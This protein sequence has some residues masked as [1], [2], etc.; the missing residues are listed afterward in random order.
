VVAEFLQRADGRENVGLL[1]LADVAD[2]LGRQEVLVDL[3]LEGGE[4]TADDLDQLRGEVLR[5]QGV[6]PAED[7]LVDQGRHVVL[8]ALGF[9]YL[10]VGG[11]RLPPGQDVTHHLPSKIGGGTEDAWRGE[12]GKRVKEGRDRR[13]MNVREGGKGGGKG[14]REGGLTYRG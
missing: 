7:E 13:G 12:G 10:G 9:E 3:F 2:F 6:G 11:V 4:A 5:V 1:P 8:A 14:G